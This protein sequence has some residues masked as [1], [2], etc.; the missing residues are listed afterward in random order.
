MQDIALEKKVD[1]LEEAMMEL[2]YQSRKTEIEIERLAVE[3]III[4]AMAYRFTIS[5]NFLT[6]QQLFSPL[7]QVSLVP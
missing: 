3:D 5:Q 4:F 2:V 6:Q 1:K 7:K